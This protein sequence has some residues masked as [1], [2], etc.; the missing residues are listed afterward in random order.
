[1]YKKSL[2]VIAF[3][4]VFIHMDLRAQ[5]CPSPDGRY[6]GFALNHVTLGFGP[7]FLYGDIKEYSNNI[8]YGAQLKYDRKVFRGLL[9]GAEGQIGNL[10]ASENGTIESLEDGSTREPRRVSNV[11]K[12]LSFN[13]S[14]YPFH[15]F[16]SSI[17][18][19]YETSLQRFLNGIYF[20]AG[21]GFGW[22]N[23]SDLYVDGTSA[24]DG[25]KVED[26]EGGYSYN[27]RTNG[28]VMPVVN[29]GFMYPLTSPGNFKDVWSIVGN[30]QVSFSGNDILDGYTP[31][32][33]G[34]Q[35]KDVYTLYT[36][37]VRYS[38]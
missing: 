14:L 25:A 36:L 1:M 23:Y 3:L 7:T 21:I 38:F 8:G 2:L 19:P 17:W 35:N 31:P 16:N 30:A 10:K 24:T 29:A 5:Y 9:L 4:M 22:N 13:L 12:I 37:G 34:N 18:A 28:T 11:Y 27:K 32:T 26:P 33:E 6:D 15:Y 20:G